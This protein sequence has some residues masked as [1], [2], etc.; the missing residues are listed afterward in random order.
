MYPIKKKKELG[1]SEETKM[2]L[3]SAYGGVGQSEEMKAR[4]IFDKGIEGESEE[5]KM[6]LRMDKGIESK[7][8]EYKPMLNR[9]PDSL[10]VEVKSMLSGAKKNKGMKIE[11]EAEPMLK[12]SD[13]K[14][15]D[16]ALSA[17]SKYL[18]A[19]KKRKAK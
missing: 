1:E 15:Y 16:E 17:E 18:E 2:R 6:R 11:V 13:K 14:I 4:Q 5:T 7:S 3:K 12:S 10:G 9:K 19:L 8:E